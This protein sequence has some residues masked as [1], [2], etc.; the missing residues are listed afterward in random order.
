MTVID[1]AGYDGLT[2][3]VEVSL[4]SGGGIARIVIRGTFS[5]AA[6]AVAR[7]LLLD[8]CEQTTVGVVLA[9]EAVVDPLGY[10]ELCHLVDVAQRRCWTAS[11]R[12]E[13]TASDAG[14]R[15]ALAAA[16]FWP[17]AG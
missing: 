2:V 3:P 8:A 17:T 4:E 7:E 11:C 13:V 14:A 10:D 5:E 12:L 1:D 6:A 16:G 9:V 15:E